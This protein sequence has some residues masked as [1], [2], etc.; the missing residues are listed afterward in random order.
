MYPSLTALLAGD[1]APIT[2]NAP[3]ATASDGEK[4][5]TAIPKAI[6][7][8]PATS[9][10][11]E[12]IRPRRAR[13]RIGPTSPPAAPPARIAPTPVAPASSNSPLTTGTRGCRFSYPLAMLFADNAITVPV[14]HVGIGRMPSAYRRDARRPG[15]ST[16]DPA[17]AVR[18]IA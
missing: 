6:V 14:V 17:V 7:I 13:S 5:K 15:F 9:A 4:A 16:S 18:V 3:T 1:V 8:P 11:R 10:V 12:P 2:A